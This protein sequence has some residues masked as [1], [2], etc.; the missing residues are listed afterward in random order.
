MTEHERGFK[1]HQKDEFEATGSDGQPSMLWH[2]PVSNTYD[3]ATTSSPC[4]P[5]DYKECY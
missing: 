5:K 3:P 4:W 2:D 1:K